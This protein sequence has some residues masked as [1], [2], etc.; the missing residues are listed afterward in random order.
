MIKIEDGRRFSERQNHEKIELLKEQVSNLSEEE[1]SLLIAT[2]KTLKNGDRSIVNHLIDQ[3]YKWTPLPVD[4]W[5]DDPYHMGMNSQTLYPQIRK[6]LC[7][8]LGGNGYREII[9]TG[10]IGYGKTTFMSFAIC[11]LLYELSCLRSPQLCYGLSPGSGIAIALVSVNLFVANKVML[12]A[13]TDKLALSQYFLEHFPHTGKKDELKF[14]SNISV[15]ISS[16]GALHR[17]LGLNVVGAAIDEANFMNRN[18][19]VKGGSKRKLSSYDDAE[20]LYGGIVR[21]IKSRFLKSAPDLPGCTILTSSA[22]LSGGF[23]ERRLDESKNDPTLFARDYAT[24]DVKPQQNFCGLR[25]KV[26]VGNGHIRSKIFSESE[27]E[28]GKTLAFYE[29]ND[30]RILD[31]PIEYKNDFDRDLE[32]SIRDIAGVSTFAISAFIQR[33]EKIDDAI[34]FTREHPCTTMAWKMDEPFSIVWEK[35][36]VQ[37]ERTLKGMYKEVYFAPRYR[38]DVGR[39]IHIDTSLSGDSTGF[40]MGYIDRHVEVVRRDSEGNE[41]ND[42]AP[43][44]VI[45]FVLEIIPPDGDQI[46]LADVRRLVYEIQDHGFHIAGFSCDSYQSADTLQ[47]IKQ[48]GVRNV[49]VSSLDRSTEGYDFLKSA[50]YEDRISFYDYPNLINE[51]RSLEYVAERG[52]VDHPVAGSKDLADAV[53]GVV[54]GLIRNTRGDRMIFTPTEKTESNDMSWVSDGK[55]KWKDG[56]E[57]PTK[58]NSGT[59]APMPIIFG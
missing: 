2:L 59:K 30:C 15:Y 11:R 35:I 20:R 53:A 28:D 18:K 45:E 7:E 13:V 3:R 12:E 5:L 22:N 36:S 54:L 43:Y 16:T 49:E 46:F 10:S 42:L 1:R 33:V 51:L 24:W 41:Y 6:D 52:K 47:Q 4:E 32:M 27:L 50:L 58:P 57:L 56:N 25:F 44:I 26:A 19:A 14:P 8:A 55:V 23:L 21:R 38:P 39:F 37:K 40:A 29:S 17:L 31:V 34:D 48:R 9:M